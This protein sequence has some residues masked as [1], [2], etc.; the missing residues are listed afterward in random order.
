MAQ[1]CPQGSLLSCTGNI[2]TQRSRSPSLT[3]RITASG[4]EIE[5]GYFYPGKKFDR[6]R[7]RSR[8]RQPLLSHERKSR[9]QQNNAI[10]YN[11]HQAS[12][13]HLI[14]FEPKAYLFFS[15]LL[16]FSGLF[17]KFCRSCVIPGRETLASQI[18]LRTLDRSPGTWLFLCDLAH[19]FTTNAK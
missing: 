2:W 6:G 11:F 8:A 4:N 7:F 13:K 5:R 14:T 18:I 16:S 3:K 12:S 1:P 17:A 19:S 15:K 9:N 10:N